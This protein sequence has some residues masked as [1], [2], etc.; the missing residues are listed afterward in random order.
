MFF[1]TLTQ[2]GQATVPVQIR[3]ALDLM[4]GDKLAFELV[5]HK[6][7]LKKAEPLDLA[8]AQ[9][10]EHTVSQEWGSDEDSKAYDGLL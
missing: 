7:V 2:K 3:D 6:V 9:A 8:Y 5:D 10:L 4:A 1:S